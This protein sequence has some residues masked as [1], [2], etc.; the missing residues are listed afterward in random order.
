MEN[1]DINPP[2]GT[3]LLPDVGF[4]AKPGEVSGNWGQQLLLG[5]QQRLA[6]ARILLA[7][8]TLIFLDEATSALDESS[9]AR[10]YGLLRTRPK[11]Q[12]P[13]IVRSNVLLPEPVDPRT[14]QVSRLCLGCSRFEGPIC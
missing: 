3:P 11:G 8:P 13:A 12:I 7:E 1:F 10:L 4:S 5:E 9:A 2:D 14:P 6:F